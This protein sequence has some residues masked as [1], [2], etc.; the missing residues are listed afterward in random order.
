LTLM[1]AVRTAC[2]KKR[3]VPPEKADCITQMWHEV[4]S[5][6]QE[7]LRGWGGNIVLKKLAYTLEQRLLHIRP[8][9][10]LRA[11]QKICTN[12]HIVGLWFSEYHTVRWLQSCAT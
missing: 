12:W 8:P 5:G 6:F 4:Y 7:H 10:Q 11:V 3:G 1:W 2:L 9:Y